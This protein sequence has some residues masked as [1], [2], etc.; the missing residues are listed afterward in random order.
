[1]RNTAS[2]VTV[3]VQGIIACCQTLNEHQLIG[4]KTERAPVNRIAERMTNTFYGIAEQIKLLTQ[5]PELMWAA[6]DKEDYFV[7]TQLFIFAR[8]INT[9]LNLDI[10]KPVMKSFPVA[11]KLWTILSS[12]YMTIKQAC[13]AALERQ[14]LT[15]EVA[16]KC[17]AS[18]M[19]LENCQL[20]KLLTTFIKLRTKAF[21]QTLLDTSTVPHQR[22][23]QKLLTSV[24][25]LIDTIVLLY[26]CLIDN[27]KGANGQLMDELNRLS[28]TDAQQTIALMNAVDGTLMNYMLP[29]IISKFK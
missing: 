15:T 9:G 23:K 21:K 7:A 20:E 6:V 11:A 18:I 14:H 24:H 2:T 3:Q 25:I 1:M 4:F 5:L 13:L 19:L 10:N 26:K 12:F 22:V 8:H 28:A 29:E 27:G 17:L 16:A